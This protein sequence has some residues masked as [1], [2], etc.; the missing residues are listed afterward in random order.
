MSDIH[1]IARPHLEYSRIKR[2][3]VAAAGEA[4]GE[5]TADERASEQQRAG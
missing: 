4:H 5:A 3:L 2:R 1:V